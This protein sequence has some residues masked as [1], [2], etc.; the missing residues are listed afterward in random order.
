MSF[1]SVVT[2][3]DGG[4]WCSRQRGEVTIDFISDS[5]FAIMPPMGASAA[6]AFLKADPVYV[7]C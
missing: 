7:S 1:K 2:I 5:P 3:K 4:K 6:A